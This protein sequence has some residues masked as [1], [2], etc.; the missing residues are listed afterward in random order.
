MILT[1]NLL[2]WTKWWA[3]PVIGNGG[4]DLMRRVK[5][6]SRYRITTVCL[7][8]PASLELRQTFGLRQKKQILVSNGGGGE[9]GDWHF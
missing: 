9:C 5:G 3:S 7:L 1:L 8:D 2:T 6:Y 4:W